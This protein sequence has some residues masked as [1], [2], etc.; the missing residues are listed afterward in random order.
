M[1][2]VEQHFNIL[3]HDQET[4]KTAT[5]EVEGVVAEGVGLGYYLRIQDEGEGFVDESYVI[6]HLESGYSIGVHLYGPEEEV[7]RCIEALAPLYDWH[8]PAKAFFALPEEQLTGVGD[9]IQSVTR[10]YLAS[11]QTMSDAWYEQL[12][13]KA[14]E[15][16]EA[17]P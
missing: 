10:N 9:A 12:S 17:Q 2:F 15:L 4:G 5:D 1:N 6:T 11:S 14:K 8:M 7:R 3:G 16:A 13:H